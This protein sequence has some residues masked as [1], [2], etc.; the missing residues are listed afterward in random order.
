MSW[1]GDEGGRAAVLAGHDAV[2]APH[3]W[4]YLDYYQGP[5]AE[6]PLAIGGSI[7]LA[8]AYAFEPVPEGLPQEAARRILGG[9]AQ[10]WSEYLPSSDA[11]AYMALPRAAALAEAFWSP[12]ESREFGE[13]LGRMEEHEAR[14]RGWGVPYRRL[15]RRISLPSPDGGIAAGAS[16]AVIHGTDMVRREDRSL[17]G[18]KDAFSFLS[19][20]VELPAARTYRVRVRLAPQA[21]KTGSWLEA[22][23]A[24]ARLRGHPAAG[25]EL[26][27]G[28][29]QAGRAG[30]HLL[31]LRAGGQPGPDG[32]AVVRGVEITPAE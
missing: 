1:R 32:F 16:D 2:M 27:L 22:V 8:R 24:G 12:R 14:L 18:W 30:P 4:T 21:L 17:G 31:F 10:L 3:R 26:D 23:I 19:W 6:E 13:F 5:A 7:S 20:S 11:V 28:V 9:Q 25:E 15:S 29:F